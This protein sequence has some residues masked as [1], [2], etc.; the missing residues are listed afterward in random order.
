M[1]TTRQQPWYVLLRAGA[2]V[3]VNGGCNLSKTIRESH[4]LT[5]RPGVH[6]HMK[7]LPWEHLNCSLIDGSRQ[8]L[9][10]AGED[11]THI[12][13]DQTYESGR[14]PTYHCPTLQL[15]LR[16]RYIPLASTKP[17]TGETGRVCNLYSGVVCRPR[18]ST[19][20]T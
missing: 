15:K 4:I 18:Y 19:G 3:A 13:G 16:I 10:P 11:Q 9:V 1:H 20:R 12:A 6:A 5:T 7:M 14:N 2:Y 17:T 8:E